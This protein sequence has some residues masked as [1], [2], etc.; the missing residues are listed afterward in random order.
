MKLL[1]LKSA[2]LMLACC[3][4][5]Q[6]ASAQNLVTFA[7]PEPPK[8]AVPVNID[9][10]ITTIDAAKGYKRITITANNI[11]VS[12]GY[13]IGNKKTGTWS[14]FQLNGSLLTLAE[15]DNDVKSGNYLEFDKNGNL[16]VLE[17]YKNGK[18]HGDQKKYTQ[19]KTGRVL[20]SSYGYADGLYHGDCI[21]YTVDGLIQS[22][23]HMLM[24][25]KMAL[26]VGIFPPEKL[27]WN[28]IIQTTS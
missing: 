27:P 14:T 10:V 18:L 25:K 24:A 22:S 8:P 16:L 1:N 23:M 7:P 9:T 3:L 28:N 19:G 12:D 5:I 2:L 21:E 17:G 15:Y 20:K 6:F 13:M 4:G 11:V 26:L